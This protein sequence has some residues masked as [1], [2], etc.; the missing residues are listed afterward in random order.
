MS[1]IVCKARQA[2]PFLRLTEEGP[3]LGSLEFSGKL[4]QGLEA[5]VKADLEPD[6][7]TKIQILALMHLNNDGV[8][9]NDRSSN[10]LAH[11][12][13]TA[14]SLSLHWRVPGIPNQEQCSY[15]WWSLTSLDRLNKPLMGA[16]PFMIDDADVGLERPEKTS[17]DYRSHVINVTLTMGDL[18]KKATK[19]YKATSTAR[20]D[21]QGD[22][23][24]LSE[25]TSG[26]SFNE[27]LQSH[28]GE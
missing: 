7:V 2:T 10:H 4:L 13:S 11:A 19:V 24:S 22:F 15:L 25:V 23:P 16:A 8:G 20:C 27:F 12:I 17:N 18:I 5:A 28:Q 26:T 3:L 14:W 1:M 6:R 21:D 9:G